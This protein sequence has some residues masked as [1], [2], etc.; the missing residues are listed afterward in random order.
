[1]KFLLTFVCCPGKKLG[2]AKTR[3]KK[4]KTSHC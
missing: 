2:K 4:P 1:M 3:A